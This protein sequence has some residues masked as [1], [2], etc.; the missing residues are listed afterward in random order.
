[1]TIN[2]FATQTK[3][4]WLNY[5]GKKLLANRSLARIALRASLGEEPTEAQLVAKCEAIQP[6]DARKGLAERLQNEIRGAFDR[7]EEV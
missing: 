2:I 5:F 6:P 3:T 7:G 1:M 4:I